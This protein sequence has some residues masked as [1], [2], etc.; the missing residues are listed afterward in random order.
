MKSSGRLPSADWTVPAAPEPSREPSCSVA[1]ADSAREHGDR[2]GGDEERR[3]PASRRG[4]ARAPR[5]ATS[6]AASP[7]SIASRLLSPP[8]TRL[9]LPTGDGYLAS[10]LEYGVIASARRADANNSR[11][12]LRRS[13]ILVSAVA[14]A[15]ALAGPAVG[16]AAD[17]PQREPDLAGGQPAGRGAARLQGARLVAPRARLGRDQRARPPAAT[18]RRAAGE[19]SARLL[20]RLGHVPQARL[21]ELQERLP[22]VRRARSSPGS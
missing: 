16:V 6:S 11:T 7:S 14:C 17:R 15:C 2:G 21:D 3:R 12:M 19:A 9:T 1:C 10:S 5:P 13:L 20:R 22:A 18:R 8:G 4:S